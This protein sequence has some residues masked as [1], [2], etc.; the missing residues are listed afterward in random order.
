MPIESGHDP[1]REIGLIQE[2]TGEIDL[3]Y[4]PVQ[5]IEGLIQEIT[6]EIDLVQEIAGEIDLDLN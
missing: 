4:N 1:I 3:V 6:D 5:G 2:I